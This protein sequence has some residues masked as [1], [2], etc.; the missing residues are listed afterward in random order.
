MKTVFW[1]FMFL[2]GLAG[3]VIPIT[4][5]YTASKLPRLESEFDV[6]SQLRHRIEGDRMSVLAGRMDGGKDR[7]SVP[8]TRPDFSRM[9]KDLVALYIR[10]MDCPTYFQTPREDGRAWAWRLFS[11]VTLGKVPPGDGACER[12]LAMRIAR[13]MGIEGDLQL[14]VAA[15]RLHAFFQKD[16]LIAYE[17]SI[18]RFERGVI[19]VEDAARKLFGRELGDLQ[20]SELAELQLALPPYGYYGDIKACKNASLIRQNRDMLLQDLAGYSLVSEERAR[21]AI[22]Q[23]VACLSV[24]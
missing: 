10:Q 15:H 24:K 6:E 16:Q 12:R 9:P 17:L 5:L 18:L 11:G 4:Y 2:V 14:S 21:N 7:A 13:E 22:A 19:G 3:V 23:P 1:L 20:L 8:F